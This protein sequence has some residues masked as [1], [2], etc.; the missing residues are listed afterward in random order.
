MLT[1]NFKPRFVV[2]AE[3]N[4]G[5]ISF[6]NRFHIEIVLERTECCAL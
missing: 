2:C 3:C 5:Q 1:K 6:K 4:R